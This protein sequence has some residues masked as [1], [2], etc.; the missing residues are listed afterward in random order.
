MA[1]SKSNLRSAPRGDYNLLL[2][3]NQL[4]FGFWQGHPWLMGHATPWR[5]NLLVWILCCYW[6]IESVWPSRRAEGNGAVLRVNYTQSHTQFTPANLVREGADMEANTWCGLPRMYTDTRASVNT[7]S[8]LVNRI[9]D[10]KSKQKINPI[11]H[12]CNKLKCYSISGTDMI[13]EMYAWMQRLKTSSLNESSHYWLKYRYH[14]VYVINF[15]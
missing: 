2:V 9:K 4:W 6:C 1:K 8:I 12:L 15:K 3:A 7:H 5:W 10:I 11:F 13:S 14:L